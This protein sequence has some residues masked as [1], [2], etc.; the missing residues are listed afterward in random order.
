MK[1]HSFVSTL[2]TSVAVSVVCTLPAQAQSVSGQGTWET[3]LLG[4]DINLQAVAATSSSAVYLYDTSLNVTWLRDANVNVGNG[5]NGR[6]DWNTAT[7]WAVNLVTGNVLAGTTIDDWRL[8]TMTDTGTPGCNFGTNCGFNP[9]T[10]TSEMANLFFNT[11]GNKAYADISGNYPQ[12]GWGLTNTGGFQNMQPDGYWLGTEFATA[13]D[14]GW[15]FNTNAGYQGG[16]NKGNRLSAMAV[17]SGDVLA[18]V[19]EPETYLMLLSGLAV[20]GV[21]GRRRSRSLGTSPL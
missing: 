6:M 15:H 1:L 8:P 20:L 3:T 4:R 18:P 2:V 11:L 10:A 13:T 12:F 14:E 7:N 5:N 19:P 16:S 21:F 17:R 9:A